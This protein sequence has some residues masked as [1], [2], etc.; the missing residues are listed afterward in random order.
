MLTKEHVLQTLLT[1]TKKINTAVIRRENFIRSP[2]YRT[3]DE[4]TKYIT[5]SISEKIYCYLN[6]IIRPKQCSNCTNP[7]SFITFQKGYTRFCSH[8]CAR[9][10]VKWNNNS[11]NKK[12]SYKDQ[13]DNFL[14]KYY[15]NQYEVVEEK[16]LIQWIKNRL[17][18]RG[19]NLI[20]QNDYINYCSVLC[21]I[22]RRTDYLPVSEK[23]NW[24]ERFYHILNNINNPVLNKY[25]P[26]QLAVYENI[27][28][29]YRHVYKKEYNNLI[30]PRG[31]NHHY[32]D[33]LEHLKIQG[34][35]VQDI[36]QI[37]NLNKGKVDLFCTKCNK[38]SSSHLRNGRW[39]VF[40]CHNCYGDPNSSRQE[41]AVVEFVREI[42]P[43]KIIENY[44]L[45]NKELDGF[46]PE[47]NLGIE[48]NGLLWHSFGKGYPNNLD[49][50]R[51]GKNKLY[52]KTVFFAKHNIQVLHLFSHEWC[53][54]DKKEIWKS[55]IKNKLGLSKKLY[56]RHCTVQEINSVDK[57]IFLQENHIQ[58]ID[59]SSISLGLFLNNE[60]LSI[61][62]FG[63]PR[64][65]KKTNVNYELIRYCC[66]KN[67]TVIGGASKILS[68]FERKYKPT[69]VVSYAD[70]RRSQGNL[71]LNLGFWLN[72]ISPPNYFY[73]YG[74]QIV[75]RYCAQKKQLTKLLGTEYDLK[76]TE[77]ENMFN[78]E[79]RRVWDCGNNVY[80]K[81]Y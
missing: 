68:Y 70:L 54:K 72:H 52:E 19:R 62:T 47:K 14:G 35:I 11:E 64:F 58:G 25:N 46:I 29:G 27:N 13:I 3:I 44:T 42:Y 63:R 6:D 74:N 77:S 53:D 24:S 49:T 21:S 33:I 12:K 2:I 16:E 7:V 61:M 60:L 30:T 51:Y 45:E 26:S 66:K 9:A 43:G 8:R 48:F 40:F 65:T 18:Q 34:F 59:K 23:I 36:E 37:K 32:K 5:G 75:K 20:Y 55:I 28:L 78:N 81:I 10:T 50:E 4:Q 15:S 22:L 41:K 38:I 17:M 69:G 67:I 31:W 39:K 76:V 73:F 71:Y 56:A 1:K 79:Y 80:I 57:N